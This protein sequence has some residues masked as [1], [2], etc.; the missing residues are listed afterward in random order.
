MAQVYGS[1]LRASAGNFIVQPSENE[2]QCLES[3]AE[4]LWKNRAELYFA[5]KFSKSHRFSTKKKLL[6]MPLK[7]FTS[8]I[9]KKNAE[10]NAK[11]K[12]VAIIKQKRK[13]LY[14]FDL[15]GKQSRCFVYD[16]LS[17]SQFFLLQVLA[18]SKFILKSY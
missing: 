1:L 15:S 5:S 8:K 11:N 6:A 4:F 7:I 14:A 12:C 16:L 9:Q 10:N 18:F 2:N 3:L 17:I 13:K